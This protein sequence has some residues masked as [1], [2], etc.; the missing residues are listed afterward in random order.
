MD[1]SEIVGLEIKFDSLSMGLRAINRLPSISM[2]WMWL[3][4]R[5]FLFLHQLEKKKVSWTKSTFSA[6][7]CIL[8]VTSLMGWFWKHV[9]QSILK[10]SID[11]DNFS[12]QT[13][14]CLF[15]LWGTLTVA[16]RYLLSFHQNNLVYF[17][18]WIFSVQK[19]TVLHSYQSV[20]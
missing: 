1:T 13:N 15:P 9:I 16:F 12:E 6:I 3:I 5:E 8:Q 10:F 18:A 7:F 20:Y 2:C 19:L 4:Q 17:A 11:Y 14:L